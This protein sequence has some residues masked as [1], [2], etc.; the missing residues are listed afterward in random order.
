M[1]YKDIV[2]F[3]EDEPGRVG[4]LAFAAALAEQHGAHL[5][6]TFVADRLDLHPYA[7]FAVGSGLTNM[8]NLFRKHTEKAEHGARQQFEAAGRARNLSLEWR[9]SDNEDGEALMLHARHACL[10]VVGPRRETAR[11]T[12]LTLAEDV[13]FSSGRPTLLVP[14]AWPS[15]R[16]GERIVV[17]WNG[18][19]EAAR[20]IADA[21]P[22]LVHARGVRLVV[23]PEEKVRHS[24]RHP[25][26]DIARHRPARVTVTV[27]QVH[28]SDAGAALLAQARTFDADMLVTA[29]MA[30]PGSAS[31]FSAAPRARCYRTSSAPFSAAMNPELRMAS[32]GPPC[33]PRNLRIQWPQGTDSL[34]CGEGE[35]FP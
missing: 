13:I 28:A 27:E 19:R 18:S 8:L 21:L 2:I 11:P 9:V 7:S 24:R 16:I 5:I 31:S 29:P 22:F 26:A 25:G 4:R 6:G 20:A 23:I 35:G 10:A 12:A 1:P 15:G 33:Q 14:P 3:L 34:R 32:F 30:G 17:G